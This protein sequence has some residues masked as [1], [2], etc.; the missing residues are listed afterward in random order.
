VA[1][2][3]VLIKPSAA[4]EYDRLPSNVGSRVASKID[5]LASE[6]R[7]RGVRKLEGGP[8]RWRV[9]AGDWRIIYSIDDANQVV[10]V[11]Y[12]RHRSRAYD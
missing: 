6:P 11:L 3:R 5:S 1:D 2:Y 7:P 9:R 4:R 12:I 10:D 8:V